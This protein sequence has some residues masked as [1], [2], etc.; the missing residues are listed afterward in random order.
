MGTCQKVGQGVIEKATYTNDIPLTF[1]PE[2]QQ[3]FSEVMY[4]TGH[5][6]PFGLAITSN[7]LCCLKEV[8][9]LRNTCL[10]WVSW[11][12]LDL[13]Q[14]VTC[15]RVGVIND[16]VEE[17]DGFPNTHPSSLL[18][19]E[20]DTSLDVEVNCLFLCPDIS[21]LWRR[22]CSKGVPCCSL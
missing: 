20:V 5:L 17:L 21:F 13:E 16:G 1:R 9:N 6:H 7:G 15:I 11:I 10:L 18:G 14:I 12:I 19:F 4:K 8:L 3:K 22:R 2:D